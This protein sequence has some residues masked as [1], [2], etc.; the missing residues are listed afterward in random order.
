MKTISAHPEPELQQSLLL[1][2]RWQEQSQQTGWR[3]PGDWPVPETE[4]LVTAHCTGD[5]LNT[6]ARSLG[7]AR[8]YHGVGI[9]E[10]MTDL[11][12][13]F[14]AAE[15]APD[16]EAT[17]ELVTGWVQENEQG[18]PSSCTDPQS[19]LATL[20]HLERLIYDMSRATESER[21]EYV[22]ATMSFSWLVRTCGSIGD[23]GLAQSL[24][25]AHGLD[26][27]H[28]GVL[29]QGAVL[30]WSLLARIG[31][32]CQTQLPEQA[33]AAFHRGNVHVLLRRSDRNSAAILR[34]LDRINL[35]SPGT[36]GAS[37]VSFMPIPAEQD[38]YTQ[39]IY[40]LRH[41]GQAQLHPGI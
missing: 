2:A 35:L 24:D 22:L 31:Q 40:Q 12:T 17:M 10:T 8:A 1:L 34:C 37:S 4:Q 16:H 15:I 6:A 29:S 36:P 28:S 7:I 38:G 20:A 14:S 30:D 26:L 9:R 3:F 13:F 32:I 23:A 18:V 33:C 25:L 11:N 21:S 5:S 27:A 19:G 39:L 41:P